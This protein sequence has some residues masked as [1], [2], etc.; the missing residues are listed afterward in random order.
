M[1][2]EN[3]FVV[4]LGTLKLTDEQRQRVNAA[5][6]KAVIGELATIPSGNKL[7]YFPLDKFKGGPIIN[8][9]IIRDLASKFSDLIK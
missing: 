5:I 9:V 4:D 2:A 8:G 3:Q 7:G 6:Q 1:A